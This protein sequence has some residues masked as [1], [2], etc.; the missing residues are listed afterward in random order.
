MGRRALVTLILITACSAPSESVSPDPVDEVIVELPALTGR[1]VILASD[2][3]DTHPAA[4]PDIP[5]ADTADRQGVIEMPI[6]LTPDEASPR[7]EIDIGLRWVTAHVSPDGYPPRGRP[8]TVSETRHLRQ[9]AEDIWAAFVTAMRAPEDESGWI[10]AHEHRSGFALRVAEGRRAWLTGSGLFAEGHPSVPVRV[11]L[12]GPI[13]ITEDGRAVVEYCEVD[14]ETVM[15]RG[16]APDGGD[17]VYNNLVLTHHG[18]L[19]FV[20]ADGVWTL[21]DVATDPT[22]TGDPC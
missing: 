6:G 16:G 13:T 5:S 14:S 21:D 11:E 2:T 9:I 20:R 8:A 19:G 17:A 4:T 15:E 10:D 18:V 3:A 22:R 12:T 7:V 1:R